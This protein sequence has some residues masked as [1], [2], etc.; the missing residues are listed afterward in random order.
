[1]TRTLKRVAAFRAEN[2]EENDY[3]F[4]HTWLEA[5]DD[6]GQHPRNASWEGTTLGRQESARLL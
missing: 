5:S 1:M 6:K 2:E 3:A 4:E